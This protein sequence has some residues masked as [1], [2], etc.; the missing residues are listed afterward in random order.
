MS[1]AKIETREKILRAA[2][3]L[4]EAEQAKGVRMRDI[5][6]AA[7]ISRQ[8]VYLHFPT[9]SDLLIATTR[10]IDE[11]FDVDGRLQASRRAKS[12]IARLDAFVEAWGNYIPQIFGVA[13]ALLALRDSDE[14]AAEAWADRMQALRHGC[15]AAVQAL[16]DDG[17]LSSEMSPKMATD[18]LWAMLSVS[19]WE[20]LIKDCGWPQE[21][22]VDTMKFLARRLLVANEAGW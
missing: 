18:C 20:L 4:L 1:S 19:Q 11:V 8:A 17:E 9:R 7:G 21:R 10:Y 13:K 22:Y 2:W 16:K 3:K 5:A 15:R 12:A 6:E 14:A